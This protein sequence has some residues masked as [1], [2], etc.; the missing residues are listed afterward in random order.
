M[1]HRRKAP[2]KHQTSKQAN[3][4]TRKHANTQTRKQTNSKKDRRQ[5]PQAQQLTGAPCQQFADLTASL[6]PTP[7]AEHVADW[8]WAPTHSTVLRHWSDVRVALEVRS[9]VVLS[10][11]L[12]C[13]SVGLGGLLIGCVCG[14]RPNKVPRQRTIDFCLAQ[15]ENSTFSYSLI[16][17]TTEILKY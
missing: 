16:S 7:T 2:P 1:R 13:W 3:K 17:Y 4:Q 11:S 9:F 10:S 6:Q 8:W 15:T 5:E 14:H 12:F